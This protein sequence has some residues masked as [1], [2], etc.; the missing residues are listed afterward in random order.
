MNPKGSR[1]LLTL[2]TLLL[3]T[4]ATPWAFGANIGIVFDGPSD[5]NGKALA[6]YKKEIEDLTEGQFT[7]TFP[8]DKIITSDW[9][10]QGVAAAIDKLLADRRVDI[11]IALGI[12]GSTEVTGRSSFPKPVIAPWV[13]DPTLLGLTP[14]S[15]GGSRVRNLYYMSR[16]KTLGRNIKKFKEIVGFKKMA[17]LYMPLVKELAPGVEI[18]V[19]KIASAN[20]IVITLVPAKGSVKETLSSIPPDAQAVY[21]TLIPVYSNSQIAELYDGLIEMKLPAFSMSGLGEVRA[22]ALI[23]LTPEHNLTREARRVALVVQSILLGNHAENYP[24]EYSEE[25][26]LSIN[27]ATASAIKFSPSWSILTEA[28][29]INEETAQKGR[30]LT[31]EEAVNESVDTNLDLLA[32]NQFVSAG[33]QDIKLAMA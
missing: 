5:L 2:L 1:T 4:T 24:V 29:L 11:I 7:V 3:F 8:E 27:M 28:T 22:G 21:V 20:N 26:L 19:K 6:T 32:A 13:I 23:G 25:E 18:S 12:I 16:Q 31:L 9:T 15:N 17:L 14:S 30:R 10:A 33:A